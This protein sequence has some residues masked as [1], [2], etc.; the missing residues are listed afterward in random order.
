MRKIVAIAALSAALGGCA[1][2]KALMPTLHTRA[3][4]APVTAP[5]A[6]P[7]ARPAVVKPAPLPLPAPVAVAPT[8]NQIVK[9]RWHF[10]AFLRHKVQ[11]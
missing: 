6:K 9:S 3:P 8:P 5:K 10:P 7:M 2:F 1:Q 11:R 4:A